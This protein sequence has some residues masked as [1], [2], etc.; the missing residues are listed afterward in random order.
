MEYY[1]GIGSRETPNEIGLIMVEI[2]KVMASKGYVL[3]SGG[4]NGADT[5]FEMGCNHANGAKEIYVP[6]DGFNGIYDGISSTG[7]EAE[8]IASQFHPAWHRCSQGAK[9]MHTRNVHQILGMDL[10]TPTSGVVCWT[11]KGSGS[12]G[13]GQAIRIARHYGIPVNDLGLEDNLQRT[14]RWL[15]KYSA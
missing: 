15:E 10:D 8:Q 11:P 13:T 5:A 9:K 2:A 1:T 7:M 6:W 14:I 12:G 3:R 4:A